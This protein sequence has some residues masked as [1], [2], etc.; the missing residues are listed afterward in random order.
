MKQKKW[1]VAAILLAVVLFTGTITGVSYANSEG[2]VTVVS[3]PAQGFFVYNVD[4]SGTDN[5]SCWSTAVNNHNG[6]FYGMRGFLSG[7]FYGE[8]SPRH[9]FH[10][11]YPLHGMNGGQY[12]HKKHFSNFAGQNI[13]AQAASILDV[14]EQTILE[15][16]KDGQTLAEISEDYDVS[17]DELL[18]QLAEQQSD[19]IDEAVDNGTLTES[20]ASNLK[21]NLD[22]FLHAIVNG[23]KNS[24]D[25]SVD[26]DNDDNDTSLSDVEA[27]LNDYFEGAGDEYFG[28]DGIVVTISLEGDEDELAY[29]V[30]LDFSDAVDYD[31]LTEITQ[32][33]LETFLDAVKSEID[34]NID[35][36]DFENAD[37]TG[38]AVDDNNSGD[39]VEYDGSSYTFS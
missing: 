36:T 5:N 16:L 3:D 33:D 34:A 15:A 28:D 26:E 18:E 11:G 32:T 14:D 2:T 22:E 7:K 1:Q 25:E 9:N 21:D 38:S 10:R 4:Q 27:T 13:I 30:S 29:Q 12:I 24:D 19:A 23:F 8:I 31:N 39:Y 6:G 37:I 35:D 20:Q 17:E